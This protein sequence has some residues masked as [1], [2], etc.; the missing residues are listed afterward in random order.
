[1][2]RPYRQPGLE[3]RPRSG[4]PD[5]LAKSLQEDLR[6]LGYLRAGIDGQFGA[7]TASAVRA[8]QYD[9]LTAGQHGSDG[10]APVALQTFNRGRVTG[11]TGVV[12]ERLAAC[13]EDILGDPRIPTLP[14]SAEPA[15]ANQDAL[16][17]VQQLVGLP[18][19]RPFLLAIFLQESGG[20]QYRVPSGDN[21]DNFIVVGLDHGDHGHP[22]RITSRGYGIGQFTLF[23]HPPTAAEVAG[24]MVDPIKNVQRAVRELRSKYELFIAGSTPGQ[25]ADDR[26]KENG[27][28]ALRPCRYAPDDPRFMTDCA[29]CA[30]EHLVDI[31]AGAP[32]YPGATDTLHATPYHPETEYSRVPDPATLGCD[33]PYAVRRYNGSGVD[34]YHYQFQV[35]ERLTRPPVSA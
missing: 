19:P 8:L 15:K 17:Q 18:V 2:R 32:V 13:I 11:L 25:Q 5:P 30:A 28:G 1:M 7:G 12:D 10:D 4:P 3:L 14:R 27:D 9:L 24:V 29:R 33:W 26:I 31:A 35:L 20:M 6:S 21:V 34:S 23:H 22:D 16:A